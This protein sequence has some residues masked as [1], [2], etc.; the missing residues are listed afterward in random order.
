MTKRVA[1][2][3]EAEK[4]AYVREL[5]A[6]LARYLAAD[7]KREKLAIEREVAAIIGT[8]RGLNAWKAKAAS[9]V[10]PESESEPESGP[11]YLRYCLRMA[12]KAK[13]GTV[14]HGTSRD[15]HCPPR[16]R[17]RERWRRDFRGEFDHK[18]AQVHEDDDE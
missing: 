18:R 8:Q 4:S 6:A 3:P 1:S 12:R 5:E 9:A 11:A 2:L 10:E 15:P 16:K 14:S 17:K 7:S 13:A